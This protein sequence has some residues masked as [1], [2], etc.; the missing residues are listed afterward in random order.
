L[1]AAHPRSVESKPQAVQIRPGLPSGLGLT[2]GKGKMLMPDD[3]SGA[4]LVVV[5]IGKDLDR[6]VQWE[7]FFMVWLL[8]A[9]WLG[10]T[11]YERAAGSQMLTAASR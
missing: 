4:P 3:F 9:V 7:G 11:G 6:S 1:R 2:V 5:E 8:K 10:T